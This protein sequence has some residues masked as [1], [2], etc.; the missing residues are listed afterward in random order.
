[1]RILNTVLTLVLFVSLIACNQKEAQ[2]F[3]L[4]DTAS[5][6]S[7]FSYSPPQNYK[8]YWYN[9]TAEISSY[10]LS[11]ARYGELRDGQA[12]LV[13]VTEPF[14]TKHNTKADNPA[15]K[16]PSVLK[17]N[18]TRKFNTGIY[19]YSMMN[20]T[21]FPIENGEQSLKVSSSVQEWCGHAYMELKNKETFLVNID[22]YFQG[23]SV[24]DLALEKTDL[25]DDIWSK[26]RLQ[27]Q[28]LKEGN[29][30][31]IP[32]FFYL[33]L[34]HVQAKAYNV[35]AELNSQTD[36]NSVYKLEYPE[37]GRSLSISFKTA[38]PHTIES[39][40]ETYSSG[41]GDSAKSITTTAKRIK[42]IRSAYWKRNAN[43][44]LV[45]R[46]SLGLK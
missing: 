42:T 24:Q 44:D 6:T 10:T 28:L 25:E 2:E 39:W 12:V 29:F 35:N 15:P 45:L 5:K 34:K 46:D 18:A 23:E 40:S 17:L 21:F 30:T 22:S 43:S 8:D 13:F 7:E 14:S 4:Q 37:L 20:S 16:D 32:A 3:E 36:G 1:M 31:M 38:F 33:R 27:P 11:Q 41:F 19:P 26:I 9:G